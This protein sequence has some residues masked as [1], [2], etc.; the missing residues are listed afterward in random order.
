[1]VPRVS[2]KITSSKSSLRACLSGLRAPSNSIES[3]S[4]GRPSEADG[5][6]RVSRWGRSWSSSCF[7]RFK[8][9]GWP[10]S[11]YHRSLVSGP[12]LTDCHFYHSLSGGVVTNLVSVQAGHSHDRVRWFLF[13]YNG[14]DLDLSCQRWV[15]TAA[16]V[17]N[18]DALVQTRI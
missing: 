13:T 6:L 10:K 4:S 3:V 2:E 9:Q 12:S 7:L 1:M 11:T 17:G 16:L 8:L 18:G 14:V 15:T 5:F